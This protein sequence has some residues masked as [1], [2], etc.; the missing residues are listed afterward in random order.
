[1][2]TFA[3]LFIFKRR[4][5]NGLSGPREADV[6]ATKPILPPFAQNK[7]LIGL[8]VFFLEIVHP[9]LD[10]GKVKGFS[11]F[12]F[13]TP[14]GEISGLPLLSSSVH[15]FY[16]RNTDIDIFKICGYGYGV[17]YYTS[18]KIFYRDFRFLWK[19]VIW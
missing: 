3:V 4:S 7:N 8:K 12:S 10:S 16:H 14:P 6:R 1:M 19:R 5:N 11:I 18:K 2:V 13:C 17:G 9:D 15:L